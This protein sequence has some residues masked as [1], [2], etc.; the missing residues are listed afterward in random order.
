MSRLGRPVALLTVVLAAVTVSACS[1]EAE[2]NASSS[3]TDSGVGGGEQGQGG[4]GQG[5]VAD[6]GAGPAPCNASSECLDP[7]APYCNN[8]GMCEA[9]PPG[10]ELGVG[11]GSAASVVFTVVFQP[12]EQKT[13]TDLAFHPSRPDELW[14]T[15]RDNDS[16]FIVQR[17]GARGSTWEKRKDMDASHFMRKPPAI[18]FGDNDLFGTCGDG[19]N[20]GND[21]MGAALFPSTL[22]GFALI[23][24]ELGSHVDMLHST[25]FCRGIAHERDNVYWAFNSTKRSIDRYDFVE[26]HDPGEDDHSDGQ[27]SR[28][29]DGQLSGSDAPGVP[30]H[31]AMDATAA[32]LFIADTG[33]QRILMLDVASGTPGANFSGLESVAARNYVDGATLTEIV[34]A[35]RLVAPS[36]I[37]LHGELVFVSDNATS[38]LW[39]FT[40][41]GELVRSLETG[42][43]PGSLAGIAFG[44]DGKLYFVDMPTSRVFRIDVTM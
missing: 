22:E 5:G 30:S 16:V 39:A 10:S 43:P 2:S 17:P 9:P 23:N 29:V 21:F 40:R 42:L 3:S 13:A 34:P 25:T 32:Q 19:D 35:G 1:D 24:G 38:R 37:D 18:A 44:P 20:G 33:S 27:I 41:A 8:T 11:D 12:D 14:V 6:G 7:L 28:Y 4:A 31:L 36:G 26:P 15:T